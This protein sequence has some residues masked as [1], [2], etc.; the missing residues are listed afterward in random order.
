MPI[1]HRT[2]AFVAQ[3]SFVMVLSLLLAHKLAPV[4]AELP[5]S[6]AVQ[7]ADLPPPGRHPAS[8]HTESLANPWG[9]RGGV[10]DCFFLP[11]HVPQTRGQLKITTQV[12][13]K[14]FIF[15]FLLIYVR[16]PPVFHP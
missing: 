4:A 2:T 8:L 11:K 5:G 9:R 13:Q 10:D 6:L 3:L 15:H 1:A 7:I 14:F 16:F 12:T